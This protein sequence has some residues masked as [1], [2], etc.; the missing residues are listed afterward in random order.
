MSYT[1][2]EVLYHGDGI[3]LDSTNT[4][5]NVQKKVTLLLTK[6]VVEYGENYGYDELEVSYHGDHIV[7]K[8]GYDVLMD[9]DINGSSRE[10]I[11]RI[12]SYTWLD[13]NGSS[14]EVAPPKSTKSSSKRETKPSR[15]SAT[16]P[17]YNKNWTVVLIYLLMIV[18]VIIPWF[19]VD[20]SWYVILI[21][22]LCFGDVFLFSGSIDS[23]FAIGEGNV[24]RVLGILTSSISSMLCIATLYILPQ[25]WWVVMV[26]HIGICVLGLTLY[27]KIVKKWG[28]YYVP[29]IF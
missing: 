9:K 25:I 13:D 21:Y 18:V 2:I 6:K 20:W 24:N 23:A 11:S 27:K 16:S 22:S 26:S 3:S 10:Y 29:G 12:D 17:W 7:I 19:C 8:G 5:Q 4:R 28:S 1:K 15:K 14:C